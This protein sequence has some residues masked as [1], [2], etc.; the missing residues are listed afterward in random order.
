MTYDDLR[1]FYQKRKDLF[2]HR[3]ESINKR[4]N[5]ISNL[6][7]AVALIFLALLYFGLRNNAL[8]YFLPPFLIAFVVLV[9]KHGGLFEKKVHLQNLNTVQKHELHTL[10]GDFSHNSSGSEFINIH[11]PY[12]HD[13]DIFGEGSL[14]QYLN[15]CNTR[16]GKKLLARRLSSK[17]ETTTEI[18]SWQQAIGELASKTDFRHEVHALSMQT[19][20]QPDDERQLKQWLHEPSFIYGKPFYRFVLN[21]FPVITVGLIFMAILLDGIT[22]YAVLA[23]ALQW[24]FLGF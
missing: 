16:G 5:I 17:P 7:L 11:H 24:V 6:R 15:R 18:R 14:F 8:F 2:T 12:T 13:L 21:V 4:I 22:P 20:E 19:D 9:R 23:A 3:L 1:D 10:D